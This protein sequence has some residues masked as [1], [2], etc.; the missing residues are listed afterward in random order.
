MDLKQ[1][2]HTSSQAPLIAAAGL[3]LQEE[4]ERWAGEGELR[5]CDPW[6]VTDAQTCIAGDTK[7]KMM[8]LQCF[9]PTSGTKTYRGGRRQP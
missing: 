3:T 1:L 4:E 7:G 8:Q 9:E 2:G 5:D 6:A